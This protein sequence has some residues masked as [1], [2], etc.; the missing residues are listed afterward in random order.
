MADITE[1]ARRYLDGD[2]ALTYRSI[3]AAQKDI[4]AAF[5]RQA[6]FLDKIR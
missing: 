1:I 2:V 4:S 6:R 3:A 5:V